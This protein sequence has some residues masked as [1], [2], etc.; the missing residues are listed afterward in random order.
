VGLPSCAYT[1]T[2]K[3]LLPD[4]GHLVLWYDIWPDVASRDAGEPPRI[5][6]SHIFALT[7]GDFAAQIEEEIR[8][9][10]IRAMLNGIT[11][12]QIDYTTTA[13]PITAD[14]PYNDPAILALDGKE[15]VL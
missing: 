11:G 7:S 15:V 1:I 9:Y 6:N 4:H 13:V 2:L 3:G 10:V 8:A 5:R 14:S 12:D